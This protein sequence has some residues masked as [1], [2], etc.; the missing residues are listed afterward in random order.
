MPS[1]QPRRVLLLEVDESRLDELVELATSAASANEVTPPL[2]PADR[3][4]EQRIAWLR[5]FH[6]DRRAGLDGPAGE[7]TWA[8][9]VDDRVVGS[10]RIKRTDDR[11]VLE[12]GLWLSRPARARGI[13]RAVL[14]EVVRQ[15]GAVDAVAVRAETTAVNRSAL[16]VLRRLGFRLRPADDEG[17]VRALLHLGAPVDDE[18]M[19]LR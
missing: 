6:R 8:V 9:V 11:D 15:A 17:N 5:E 14:A 16:A 1:Q 3:W 12:T 2:T 10:A 4:S 7:A 13:G 19:S 18:G